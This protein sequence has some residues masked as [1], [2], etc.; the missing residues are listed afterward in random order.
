MT[1]YDSAADTMI[2]KRRAYLEFKEHGLVEEFEE[3]LM[4]VIAHPDTK[5]DDEGNITDVSAQ[6]TLQW[7]GY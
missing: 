5:I 1:Y 2:T 4:H 6:A 7:I 3:F